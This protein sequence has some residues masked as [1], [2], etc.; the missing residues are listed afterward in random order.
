MNEG[1]KL[2]GNI[3]IEEVQYYLNLLEMVD[4]A[5]NLK[6]NIDG[7]I[8]SKDYNFICRSYDKNVYIPC[9]F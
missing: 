8:K 6:E 7:F 9:L 4:E 2:E 5:S 3:T 1:L